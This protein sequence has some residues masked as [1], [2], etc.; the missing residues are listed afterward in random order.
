LNIHIEKLN[1]PIE[2]SELVSFKVD[3]L[4]KSSAGARVA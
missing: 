4:S 2:F 1:Y 3:A